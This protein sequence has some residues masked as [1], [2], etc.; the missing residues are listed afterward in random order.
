MERTS[1][2]ESTSV[3]REELERASSAGDW[4]DATNMLGRL[5]EDRYSCR[6]YKSEPVPQPVI[7]RMLSLAQLSASWCNSQPWKTIVTVGEGTERFRKAYYDHAV[8]DHA[9]NGGVPTMQPDFTFPAAYRGIYK[10]RQREVGWQLYDS[11]G[12]VFGD[13]AASGK[14]ALENFRLFGAPHALI[15]TSE[16]DLGIYGAIDCGLYLGSLLLAA[17]SLGLGMIPQAALATYVARIL[18]Y[19]RQPHGRFRRF[20]RLS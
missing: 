3:S 13:R 7:E 12:V 1:M 15:V 8:A 4:P 5:L 17:Q 10:E 16:R 9:A 6:G 20:V 11:V 14:Q 2:T 19:S 18:R